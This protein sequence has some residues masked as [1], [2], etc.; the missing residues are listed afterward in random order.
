[1]TKALDFQS[2]ITALQEFWAD[3]GCLIWQPYYSQLGAGT[4]NPATFLRA[5]GPEP[6]NVAYVEPS[7]RPAD[8]RYGDNPNRLQCFYQ[9]QVILKPDPG[10]P[11]ELYLQSLEAI[12]IDPTRHD[13][14]FVEDNW[15]SPV[16][17]AWG[18]GWEVWMDGLEITQFTYFQQAGGYQL[19]P[20]S[21]ELTYGLDRIAAPLQG[22]HGFQNIQWNQDRTFGDVNLAAEQEHSTYYFDVADVDRLRQ[23]F[24]LFE[25]EAENARVQGLVLP[26]Y[27]YVLKCSHTFNA[28]DSRGAIGVTERQAYFA[29]MRAQSAKVA[30]LYLEQRQRLEYPWHEDT[31]E[32]ITS[33]VR[34]KKE[35]GKVDLVLPTSPAPFLL[36]IGTEEMPPGDLDDALKQIRETVPA[37]LDDLRLTH[38]EVHVMGTPRRLV[39]HVEN[40]A[41]C[42]SDHQEVVKGPPATRAFDKFGDPTKAAEGFARSKGVPVS[43]LEVREM[44]GGSYVVANV[45]TVGRP[46]VEVLSESLPGLIE[47]IRFD[48][49][50]RWNSTN[51][52]FSRPIR[53]LVAMFGEH[54]VSFEYADLTSSAY[55]RG[56][57]FAVPEGRTVKD[58]ADYFDFLSS[59][60]RWL[61]TRPCWRRSPTWWKRRP[62]CVGVSIKPT[63]PSPAMC[64][65]R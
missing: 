24:D 5:L 6:W 14:R 36:E 53:W 19:D 18:L 27:D 23:M 48:K 35:V 38:G 31:G 32:T 9:Y 65:C 16:L 20:V 50:M 7:V 45:H 10:N 55:T 62:L 15:E 33:E 46:A 3:Y 59:V 13:I 29:R 49:S 22:V 11:Q 57:R 43:A 26:A 64:W 17:G 42:Q 41:P 28:L 52:S 2:M 54:P 39:L 21:V 1:M 12:G 25:A 61:K 51:V 56:L 34:G 30:D 63:F 40:L 44:D 37:L 58:P 47:G 4:M 8:G 60:V